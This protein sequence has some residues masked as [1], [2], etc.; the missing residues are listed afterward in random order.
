MEQNFLSIRKYLGAS[1]VLA[2]MA[3]L[4]GCGG[5]GTQGTSG[6]SAASQVRSS[7]LST[8][9]YLKK[10]NA[11]CKRTK[12]RSQ[13]GYVHYAQT[14]KVPS[15]GSGLTAKAADFVDTVFTPIYQGQIN[16]LRALGAPKGD[17]AA[18]ASIIAA[19]ERGL[20]QSRAN[21]LQ[22]I[23]SAPFF[24]EASRLSVAYGMTEC[25]A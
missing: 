2:V 5:G 6:G 17:E 23:R 1:A 13:I 16:K 8:K 11:L 24:G 18:V 22:F 19:M 15:S 20:A 3:L 12:T 10:A 25:S 7:S 21:P 4:A 9:A 14:H